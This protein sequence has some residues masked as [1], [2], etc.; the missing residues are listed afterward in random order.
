MCG[1]TCKASAQKNEHAAAAVALVAG[2]LHL[3]ISCAG[4][5][6]ASCQKCETGQLRWGQHDTVAR[7]CG[8]PHIEALLLTHDMAQDRSFCLQKISVLA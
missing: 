7:N 2:V 1:N 3:E 4:A 8:V 6:S 5:E